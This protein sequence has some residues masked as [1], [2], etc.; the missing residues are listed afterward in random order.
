MGY[1][2]DIRAIRGAA[3]E[4][5]RYLC[6]YLTKQ[7]A[8]GEIGASKHRKRYRVSRGFWPGGR[9]ELE[10]QVFGRSASSSRWSVVGAPDGTLGRC[11]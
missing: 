6:K 1:V 2:V 11:S 4:V 3:G 5:P 7:T 9:Q 8:S 10:R